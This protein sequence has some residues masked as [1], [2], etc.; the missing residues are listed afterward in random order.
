MEDRPAEH[1]LPAVD[2]F[3]GAGGLSLGLHQAGFAATAAV[4]MDTDS[5]KTYMGRP[6]HERTDVWDD[7]LYR[8]LAKGALDGLRG[9]VSVVAGGPPCQPWSSG[10]HR[11]GSADARDGLP[12]FVETVRR[13][14]PEAFL[15]ENVAG[16]ARG[17]KRRHLDELV[18]DLWALG[19]AVD[20]RLLHAA[21]YGVPQRRVRLFV[22][23]VRSHMR[24]RW[25]APTHGPGRRWPHKPAGSVLTLTGKGDPNEAIVTYAKNPDIRPDAYDGQ[26][27]N[28]GGRPIDLARPAP[29]MLASMGGNKTPWVDTARIVPEYHRHLAAGGEPR[30]GLVPGARRISVV[31]AAALQTF[32][33]DMRFEGARSSQYRQVG[34]AVPVRLAAA[35]GRSLRKALTG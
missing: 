25:P 17:G 34:N 3:A 29:T 19:Y 31:E 8:L 27:Y 14:E 11:K 16:L 28:G 35:V 30:S 5:V 18:G 24:F 7:D 6:E 26:V 9:Q 21:D 10:G 33:K 12:A 22:V 23:G 2:L 15:L 4:E 13:L 32:P 1:R 20:W